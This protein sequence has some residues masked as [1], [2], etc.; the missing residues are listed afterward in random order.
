[1][2]RVKPK[3]IKFLTEEILKDKKIYEGLIKSHSLSHVARI[4]NSKKHIFRIDRE[5]NQFYVDFFGAYEGDSLTKY[6]ELITLANNL[7]YFPSLLQTDSGELVKNPK[8]IINFDVSKYAVTKITFE[9]K[10]DIEIED[11]PKYL[12]H[13]TPVSRWEKIEKIGLTPKSQSKLSYHP[14]RI[15]LAF[16]EKEVAELGDMF[17][18]WKN[19]PHLILQ[20]DTHR[21]PGKF[22]LFDDPNF[23]GYGAYTLN[24]IPPYAIKVVNEI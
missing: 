3:I 20:I 24:N 14:E 17:K 19:E 22:R 2:V 10:Y 15:Y 1:M 11:I 16:D 5:E 12:Y 21:V 13:T 9:A 7:G 18:R 23:K 6:R 8:D 4:L